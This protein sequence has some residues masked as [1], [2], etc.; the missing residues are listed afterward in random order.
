MRLCTRRNPYAHAERDTTATPSATPTTTP[1]PTPTATPT[2]TPTV[3]PT[4]TPRATPRSRP[5]PHRRPTPPPQ[6]AESIRIVDQNGREVPD[7]GPRPTPTP[8]GMTGVIMLRLRVG[9]DSPGCRPWSLARVVECP[10]PRRSGF[11]VASKRTFQTF[12]STSLVER[13][14]LCRGSRPA[15]ERLRR[16][17]LSGCKR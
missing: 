1:S 9:P 10:S 2:V 14:N 4:P 6:P 7:G 12:S 17:R 11:G 15:F 5:T 13:T 8:I 3:S 16:S